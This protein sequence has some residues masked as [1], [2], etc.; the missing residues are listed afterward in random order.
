VGSLTYSTLYFESFEPD[1][2]RKCGFSKDHKSNQPQVLLALM[3][4]E[5]GLPLDYEVFAGNIYEGKTLL[6]ALE[7]I[8]QKYNIEEVVL[9]ADSANCPLL[10]RLCLSKADGAPHQAAVQKI[11]SRENKAGPGEGPD[12]HLMG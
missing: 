8:R 2:L 9:V 1:E 5:E 10:Y 11:I 6:P 7:K 4:T 3:V 12:F